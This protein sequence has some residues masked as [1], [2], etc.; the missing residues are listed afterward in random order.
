MGLTVPLG[1]RLQSTHLSAGAE[2]E[3][4]HGIQRFALIPNLP[5]GASVSMPAHQDNTAFL[6]LQA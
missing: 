5:R 3:P 1:M 2:H 6:S 4:S